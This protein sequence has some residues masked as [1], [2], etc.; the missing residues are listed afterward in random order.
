MIGAGA[1]DRRITIQRVTESRDPATNAV[2]EAWATH[3]AD[4]PASVKQSPGREFLEANQITSERRAVFT[5]RYA[6]ITVKDRVRSDARVYNIS[7]IR[8]I[9]RRRFLELQCEAVE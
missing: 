7:D 6:E 8:E 2:V 4:V 1:F 9:G 5:I 3:L